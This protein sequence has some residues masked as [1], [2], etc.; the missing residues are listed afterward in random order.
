MLREASTYFLLVLLASHVEVFSFSQENATIIRIA[1]RV[2][3]HRAH[4][5]KPRVVE[6]TRRWM[7]S[8][9]R[10]ASCSIQY[11]HTHTATGPLNR[12]K[13]EEHIILTS[14]TLMPEHDWMQDVFVQSGHRFTTCCRS[15]D[16]R[17]SV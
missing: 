1:D 8:R 10:K 17:R 14:S 2:P 11:H 6:G 9:R 13:T 7:A 3:L 16:A 5:V 4:P 12:L 15:N